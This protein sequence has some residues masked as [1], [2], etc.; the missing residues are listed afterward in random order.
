MSVAVEITAKN[1]LVNIDFTRIEQQLFDKLMS[2]KE[3]S[4]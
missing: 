2:F 1:Y 4:T 3:K